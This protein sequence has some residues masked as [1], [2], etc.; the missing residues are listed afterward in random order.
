MEQVMISRQTQRAL[1]KISVFELDRVFSAEN[2][3]QLIIEDGHI[4]GYEKEGKKK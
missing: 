1:E 4:T 3:C 2:G